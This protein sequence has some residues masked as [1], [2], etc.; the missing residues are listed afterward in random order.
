MEEEFKEITDNFTEELLQNELIEGVDNIKNIIRD[1][2]SLNKRITNLIKKTNGQL[3]VDV[4]RI[5]KMTHILKH[6]NIPQQIIRDGKI[7][8]SDLPTLKVFIQLLEDYYLQSPQTD[9]KYGAVAK[10]E[11]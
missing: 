5:E 9:K 10:T 7:F 6:F 8:V 3:S 1:N 4:V 2:P 11:I